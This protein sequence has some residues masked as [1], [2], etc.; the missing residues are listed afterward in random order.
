[1]CFV[2]K[3]LLFCPGNWFKIKPTTKK[4]QTSKQDTCCIKLFV[5]FVYLFMLTDEPWCLKILK[6]KAFFGERKILDI[7]RVNCTKM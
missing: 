1:M 4:R 7:A 3:E 2:V 6:V 5:L